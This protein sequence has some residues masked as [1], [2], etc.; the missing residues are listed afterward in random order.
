MSIIGEAI[1]SASVEMLFKKLTSAELLQFARQ[2]E[3][4]ADLKK[5]ERNL[6]KI[7]AVLSDAKEKQRTKEPVKI[8]LA[9]L[10]NLA[11]DVEDILDEF[12]TEALRRKLLLEREADASTSMVCRFIP[13]CCTKFSPQSLKFNSMMMSNIKEITVR[14]QDIAMEK[15]NLHLKENSGEVCVKKYGLFCFI[16]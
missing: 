9:E 8:W 4:L 5:W 6:M 16:V 12:A 7:Q 15:N 11:Y 1:L 2:E 14:L 13:T 10:R 3:I